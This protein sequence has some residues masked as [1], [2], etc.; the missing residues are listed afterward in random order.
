MEPLDSFAVSRGGLEGRRPNSVR[1]H[2]EWSGYALS[3]GDGAD[4]GQKLNTFV[5]LPDTPDSRCPV[6]LTK[7]VGPL[8]ADRPH[9][10]EKSP[11][12]DEKPGPKG[13][14]ADHEERI[15]LTNLPQSVDFER[16]YR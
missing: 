12:S 10:V 11:G 14:G 13:N 1:T 9:V 2:T 6:I 3:S 15:P 16:G 4:D 7:V 5:Y 8:A